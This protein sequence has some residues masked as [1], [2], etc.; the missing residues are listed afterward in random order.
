M[1]RAAFRCIPFHLLHYLAF[2]CMLYVAFK[3]C[4]IH[5][6]LHWSVYYRIAMQLA[7]LQRRGGRSTST[8]QQGQAQAHQAR[9]EGEPPGPQREAPGDRGD[10]SKEA[11]LRQGVAKLRGCG[12]RRMRGSPPWLSA[13]LNDRCSISPVGRAPK[14]QQAS[15]TCDI[16]TQSV[17]SV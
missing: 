5:V 16:V 2:V 8:V 13:M 4:C 9:E 12:K 11:R 14:P 1:L 15:D 3:V 6:R 10:R 17:Q 7:V